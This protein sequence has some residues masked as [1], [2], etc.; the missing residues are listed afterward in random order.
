MRLPPRLQDAV[1]R[2]ISKYG[3]GALTR[4]ASGLSDKYRNRRRAVEKFIVTDIER[5]AYAAIRMPATYAAVRAV[6]AEIRARAPEMKCKSLLDLGAGT[7][8]AA[9]AALDVFDDLEQITMVEQ[10]AALIELGRK[11]ASECPHEAL[12][13]AEWQRRDLT[14]TESFPAHDLVV[15]SYSLGEVESGEARGIVQAAWRAARQ[16]IAVIEPGTMKGFETILGSRDELIGAGGHII[17]PCPHQ[18]ACPMA[19]H[20]KP[21][22]DW[23]H[24]AARFERSSLHRRVKGAELG[25]EDEK[26]SYVAA[27]KIPAQSAAAR[28]IRHPLIRP[29]FI[30]LQLCAE[31]SLRDLTITRK[32]KEEWKRARKAHWGDSW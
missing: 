8:A 32:N 13:S 18:R 22:A 2:E 24:F 12:R 27:A 1:E 28:V 5:L 23:C 6:F 4:A 30:Q 9:W 19:S 31:E 11:L 14:R 3:L 17:A 15:C 7:G 29:G 20:D 16:I 10:D 26:Y 25:Y 21:A